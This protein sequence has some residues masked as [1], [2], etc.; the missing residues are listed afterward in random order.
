M[1]GLVV[2]VAIGATV[3]VAAGLASMLFLVRKRAKIA[4]I[5]FEDPI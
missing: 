1:I 4:Q 2:G 3:I 5:S